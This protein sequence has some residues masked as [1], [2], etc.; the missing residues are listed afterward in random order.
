MT[1]PSGPAWHVAQALA[2]NAIVAGL[3]LIAAGA[4]T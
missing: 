2:W 3:L 4:G 1:R